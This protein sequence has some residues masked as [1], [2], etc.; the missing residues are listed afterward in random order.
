M[1]FMDR[2]GNH[3]SFGAD[4]E[5][6]LRLPGIPRFSMNSES[7]RKHWISIAILSE[8]EM[9]NSIVVTQ[10]EVSVCHVFNSHRVL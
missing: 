2:T 9:D 3:L 10:V 1:L 5:S 8:Q 7:N 4:N 6:S